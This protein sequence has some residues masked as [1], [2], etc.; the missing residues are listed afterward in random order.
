MTDALEILMAAFRSALSVCPHSTQQKEAWL[1]RFF[2]CTVS[3]YTTRPGRIA[4]VYQVQWYTG[5]S[6]LIE[7]ELTE[8]PKRP[9]GMART[10]RFL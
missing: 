5:K 10:L 8:L 4:W 2:F 7:K 1:L 6:S 9:G 3:A